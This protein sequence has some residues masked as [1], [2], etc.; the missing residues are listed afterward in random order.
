MAFDRFMIAPFNTGLQTDERPFLIPEDAFTTLQ[1]A[2]VFRGRVR[3]RFGSTLMDPNVLNSRLRIQVGTIGSPTSPVPVGNRSALGQAFSAGSQFFTVYQTGTPAAMLATG[4][5]TGTYNTTTGA[6]VLSGTGLGAGTPIYYYPALPVMGLTQFEINQINNHPSY[7]FDTRFAYLYTGGSGWNLSTNSPTWQGNTLNFFWT[8][9]WEG[10]L[11]NGDVVN[12]V[13]FVTNFNITNPNGATASTDDP[14]YYGYSTPSGTAISTWV[15][16]SAVA[17]SV[18][19]FYFLPAPGDPPVPGA[20][21]DSAFVASAKIILPFKDRLVLL[22][23]IECDNASGAGV[24]NNINYVNRCRYSFNGSPF[25][26]NAWYEQ[27]QSDSDGNGQASV[28]AGGGYIDAATDE[29]IV[30][31]EFIK[32]RLIVYF[33]RSTWEL[34]YTG[35]EVLPFVWQKI[36]T[37]LGSQSTFSTVPFDTAVLTIGQTGVHQCNGANVSRIDDKIPDEIF[38]YFQV[39][40]NATLRTH[41]IRDYYTELVYWAFVLN[42]ENNNVAATFPNQV[43]VYNYK[44]GSWAL[45]DD[46]ITAMG[47]FEQSTDVTWAS[48]APTTW[49]QFSGTWSSNFLNAQERQIIAGT[50]EGFIFIIDD[51]ENSNAQSMQ[52]TNAVLSAPGIITLTIYNHNFSDGDFINIFNLNGITITD[53]TTPIFKVSYVDANTINI[54][55]NI[56]S[57]AYI[58]GGTASRVSNIQIETKQWNPYLNNDRNFYLHKIDFIVAATQPNPVSGLGGQITV[59]YY[60]SASDQSMLEAGNATGSIMGTSVLETTPYNPVYYPLE[61]YQDRLTHPLYFQT[62]GNVIELFMYLSDTQMITPEISLSDFELQGMCLF[63]QPVDY[64]MQ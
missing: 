27:N 58:G 61:Q 29:Q 33:E 53:P 32:D 15:S 62:S 37:E 7:A 49:A 40:N 4:P 24:G 5:G 44:N 3:K 31:A 25:A 41:G 55:Y 34:V 35:N 18:T 19:A 22:N 50:P 47:Y 21:V 17:S 46:T 51:D 42:D 13:L 38:D 6:F 20:R 56:A 1:N 54:S 2:Y 39:K 48:S 52:I 59:D 8:C 30:S 10:I 45:N 12:N 23:T 11:Q 43:L 26:L 64:R 63:C 9:N 28:A 16:T 60:P 36:N 57:G 14:I